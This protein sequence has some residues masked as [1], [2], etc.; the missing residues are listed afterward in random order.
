MSLSRRLFHGFDDFFAPPTFPDFGP[1][2]FLTDTNRDSDMVLRRSS[3]CYEVTENDNQYQFGGRKIDKTDE[4]GAVFKS[5]TKF[6]KRFVLDQTIDASKVTA[7]LENGV[8][9]V[10]ALKDPERKTVKKIAITNGVPNK[11]IEENPQ[12]AKMKE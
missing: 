10:T 12:D 3:P 8:L 5:E 1:V 4:D 7:N 11:A 2:P 6:E 9:T